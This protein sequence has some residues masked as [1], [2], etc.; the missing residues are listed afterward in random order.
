[1]KK[2]AILFLL[3]VAFT[4]FKANGQTKIQGLLTESE[5]TPL[6]IDQKKPHFSW[7]ISSDKRG[8]YQTAYRIEVTSAQKKTVWDSGKESSG[9]SLNVTYEGSGLQPAT[10][11]DWKVTVWDQDGK[12]F[13]AFSWFE[14][15]LMNPDPKLSAWDG[16]AWIGGGDEDLVLYAQYFSIF[17]LNYTQKIS[18]GSNRASFILG[19]N[20][21]RLMDRNKNIFQLENKKDESYIKFELDISALEKSSSGRAKFN[22]YRVG[23][24][25]TD[26]TDVPLASFDVSPSV[27]NEENKHR[28]HHFEL[29]DRWGN[30]L[31]SIDGNEN[32]ADQKADEN[33][34]G[35]QKKSI[36]VVIN[37]FGGN[38]AVNTFG[39]LGEMGF[40]VPPDQ[41]AVFSN[42]VVSN[43]RSPSHVLFREDLTKTVY[44]GIYAGGGE[45]LSVAGGSYQING[46]DGGAFI[47]RDPSRN[48]MPM[49]RT[50]FR[51]EAKKIAQARL[52][53]T[54]RGIYEMYLNGER[55]GSDYYNPGLTQY[56]RTH[57][58]Q[59]YDVTKL[60]RRGEN[61]LGAMLGEGWWSG[62]LSF[63]A[64]VNH[65]G[66][67]Q[68]LLAKLVVTYEDGTTSL[69]TTN[70]R[71]WK[72]FAGGPVIYGSLDLGEVYDATRETKIKGWNTAGYD[73]SNWKPAVKVP[74]EG[75]VYTDNTGK[76]DYGKMKLVGQIG[77]NAGI[78]RVLRARSVKEVRPG[79]F[80]YD[81]GQ[82]LTGVPRVIFKHGTAD[83]KITLRVS[84]M[85]YPDLPESKNN[86]GMIMTENYRA[87]LS[88]DIYV[89]KDGA[90]VFQPRFTSHGFQYLEVTGI[91][92]PL[93]LEN[94]QGV[95]ISSILKLTADYETSNEKVNRLWSNLVWSNVDNFLSIPTD[96][97]QRNERM[98]WG[99]DISVFSPTAVYVSNTDQFFRRHLLAMRDMQL[100]NGRFTDI[101]P[102]GGGGGGVLWGS[103]GIIL[104]WENYLQFN[105]KTLLQEHY[106]A[107]ERYIDYLATTID[108]DTGLSTDGALGDWLGPQYSQLGSAF[109]VTAYHIYDLEI[110]MKVAE[111]LGK[112]GDVGKYARMHAERKAFFNT[113]FV[114]AERKTL[115][116][117]SR[118]RGAPPEWKVA[119]TQTSYAVGLALGAF[120]DEN[121]PFMAKNL[122]ETVR[123]KNSDDTG[124]LRGE[125]SLMTGF[126]GTSWISKALSEH[127]AA[128]AAYRLLQNDKY[129]SWLYPVDQ[130]AT[131]IWERLNG[132]TK[133][134]GFGGN[135]SMNSFNHYSFGAVGRWLMAYSLGIERD[136]KYPGFKHFILQPEPDPTGQM[137]WARGFY[138]SM[139]GKI[140]S[141][142]RVEKGV[143]TYRA[144][145]PANTTATLYLPASSGTD[146]KEGGKAVAEARGI[147]FIRYENGKAV[148]ELASGDYEFI[149]GVK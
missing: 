106:P 123:R 51:T 43:L 139:Y 138:D 146:V 66:D 22:I 130:G 76:Y 133:E 3:F 37:P 82:N 41:R 49:L 18:E 78:F 136:A 85:L 109:L 40:A 21:P 144:S 1:M 93:P 10:R 63:D 29:K 128:D 31:I 4:A 112:R 83:R 135:N 127:D 80:V 142:W 149:S 125:Y 60:L 75:T 90:Q 16:A 119:D 14:T 47:V 81:M 30:F 104:A 25:D 54:A 103:A 8:V 17:K 148:Y 120:S 11:Y 5:I 2:I 87:A 131:T 95:A 113:K 122:A 52:Y 48:S 64:I 91:D 102:V 92:K 33:Q 24:T 88:Q 137:T 145:V 27:I 114:N 115:G 35:N 124:V 59:T 42:V 147:R 110:M 129:P 86:V 74:L 96:C 71:T 65:F 6:G 9:E 32:F 70:D 134:N 118:A 77:N 56:P 84:E 28:E 73:D 79:V 26:K 97:P 50:R 55:V 99:G 143:L 67:R 44:D 61:A 132:Y 19:A 72:Y 140:V 58:Y 57:L 38:G 116:Y 107:M 39:M 117:T 15:G 62:L 7:Q 23:Y 100:A 45:S 20:D 53:V 68:S 126:I 12:Q 36:S 94:V 105:N 141:S 89:M 121:I 108:K 13:S 69:V 111:I 101:A 46:G 98:G 34:A